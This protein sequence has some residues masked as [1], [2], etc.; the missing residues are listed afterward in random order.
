[1]AKCK[2]CGEYIEWEHDPDEEVDGRSGWTPIDLETGER[3]Q[4]GAQEV[5][6]KCR[7]CDKP[8]VLRRVGGKWKPFNEGLGTIHKCEED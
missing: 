7:K 6:R 2:Y 3:H 4:C 1:M 8:I 5:F